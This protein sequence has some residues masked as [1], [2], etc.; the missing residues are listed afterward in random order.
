MKKE[1]ERNTKARRHQGKKGVER[2]EDKE[3]R[4]KPGDEATHLSLA[5]DY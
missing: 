1:E 4:T 2:S 3:E 5:T